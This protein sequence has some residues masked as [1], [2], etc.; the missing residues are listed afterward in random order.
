MK[1]T[2]IAHLVVPGKYLPLA[3]ACVLITGLGVGAKVALEVIGSNCD[4]VA[5][6]LR[7]PSAAFLRNERAR[8]NRLEHQ[9]PAVK[10]T[11]IFLLPTNTVAPPL[12]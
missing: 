1:I 8:T 3:V 12:P 2:S 4:E 5:D 10:E 6:G 9:T 11:P 7:Y